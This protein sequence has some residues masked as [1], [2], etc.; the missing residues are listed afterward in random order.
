VAIPTTDETRHLAA[1]TGLGTPTQSEMNVLAGLTYDQAV[2]RL[3]GG[4]TGKA[5]MA[6]PD[7]MS[8]P[9][10]RRTANMIDEEKR[11]IQRQQGANSRDLQGW[12]YSEMLNTTSTFT[13]SM[14]LFWHNHFTSSL[15]KVKTPNLLF[16]QNATLRTHALGNFADML[17]A[18]TF[19]PAMMKY[20][21]TVN[22]RAGAPNENFPREL[23]ELFTLGEGQ[24][25][26]EDDIREAARA[27]TGWAY[28]ADRELILRRQAHDNDTK[29]FFGRSGNFD[30][31]DI[32]D[33]LL[34][35]PRVAEHI[36]EK[37]WRHFVSAT[38]NSAEITRL[39]TVF[40]DSAY[41]LKPL[42]R[43]MLTSD[44]FRDPA[45]RGTLVKSPTELVAGT[46]RLVG[47]IPPDPTG[48]LAQGRNLGQ[49]LFNPPN[50]KGWP[51]GVN[52]INTAALPARYEWLRM[53]SN[54]IDQV[55]APGRGG[56]NPATQ[57]SRA[58]R[59]IFGEGLKAQEAAA[60]FA[61]PPALM[62]ELMLP[63]PRAASPGTT[64][65]KNAVGEL[66]LDPVFQLK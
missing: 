44:T 38:P 60:F 65:A 21:D 2:D 11:E 47:F 5:V 50:V 37:L 53:I 62:A 1:R 58:S 27:F 12:W 9:P 40:R 29:S 61:M 24:G 51:G 3:L 10:A 63:I 66:L 16:V 4:F 41:D 23:M 36:T 30:G 14:T 22:S 7:W 18:M 15:K 48:L 26:T 32:I 19:D 42:I 57:M 33:I 20:L 13:E 35:Q 46:L 34:E 17:Q 31:N 59:R 52:W 54:A 39:A 6:P 56:V 49:E 55:T 45:T 43:E 64:G 8:V 25:Y 28:G